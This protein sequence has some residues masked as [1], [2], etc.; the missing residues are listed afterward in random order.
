M[1]WNYPDYRR[2][3][4]EL[5]NIVRMLGRIVLHVQVAENSRHVIIALRRLLVR[6]L[7][8]SI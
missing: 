1:P 5:L 7:S 2:K 8:H 4:A 6:I 3:A